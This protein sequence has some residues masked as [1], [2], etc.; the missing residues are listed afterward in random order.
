LLLKIHMRKDVII[1]VFLF[2]GLS[3]FIRY[4]QEELP[5]NTNFKKGE[6]LEYKASYG[7]FTV[8]KGSWQ[9]QNSSIEIHD[10]PNYQVDVHGGTSGFI[11][12][13]AP[14][15][16]HWK[17]YIDTT[18]LVTHLALRDLVEGKYKKI[19]IT[20]FHFKDSLIKVKDMNF[21][22]NTFKEAEEYEMGDVTRGMI[23]GFMYLRTLDMSN[24]VIGDTISFK[25]FLDDTFYD[26]Q[27]ICH[28]RE[29]V[30]TRAGSF[31]S[32]VFRP[33]MPENSI[34]DGED[35]VLAWI[36]DDENKIPLKVEAEMFIG[37]AGIELTSFR[38][39]RNKPALVDD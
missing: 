30:K 37:H 9:I 13:L 20:E 18:T 10:R 19:D 15:K 27:V 14:V 12:F 32:I 25:A 17:S 23:S 28:G 1:G 11:G 31:K 6:Y 3:S 8:G 21:E 35:A 7:I 33:V 26:F 4:H 34:F 22:T 2:I 5:V 29:V 36:S 24:L 39:L 16:D 38:G